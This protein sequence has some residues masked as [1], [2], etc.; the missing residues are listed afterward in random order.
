MSGNV[1][2]EEGR[3]TCN[4]S[5]QPLNLARWDASDPKQ[6]GSKE[7]LTED[8]SEY[9]CSVESNSSGSQGNFLRK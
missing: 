4:L 6:K 8:Y 7:E 3:E 9:W 5:S 1:T 2:Q